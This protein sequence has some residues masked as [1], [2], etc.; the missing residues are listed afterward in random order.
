VGA[1]AHAPDECLFLGATLQRT[2]LL[3]L[4]LAAPDQH[5]VDARASGI[6]TM[7]A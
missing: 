1:G 3:A 6:A 5:P 2:A 7:E 4:L